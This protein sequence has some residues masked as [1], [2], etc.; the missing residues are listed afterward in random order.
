VTDNTYIP[1]PAPADLGDAGR[2][3]WAAIT[4]A[5]QFDAVELFTVERI[6]GLYD[7]ADRYEQAVRS[8]PLTTTSKVHGEVAHPLAGQLR[9]TLDSIRKLHASLN[10]PADDDEASG[11]GPTAEQRSAMARHIANQRWHPKAAG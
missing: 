5:Y 4:A 3:Y 8:G 1:P 7:L 11:D 9:A 10:L 6:A 2:A